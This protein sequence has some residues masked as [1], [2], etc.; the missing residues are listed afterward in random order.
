MY[1]IPKRN[2]WTCLDCVDSHYKHCKNLPVHH[3]FFTS[4]QMTLL[5]LLVPTEGHRLHSI[6]CLLEEDTMN[7]NYSWWNYFLLYKRGLLKIRYFWK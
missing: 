2:S 6:D 4:S 1:Y 7:T 5:Q 3:S